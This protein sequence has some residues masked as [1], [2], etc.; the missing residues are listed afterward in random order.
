M[1]QKNLITDVAGVLVGNADDARLA[2]GVSAIIFAQPAVV[3]VDVRGG[4]PATR[5]TD[6]LEPHRTVERIDAVVLSGGSAF[7]L[8]AGAGAQAF[9]RERGR[10]FAIGDIRVPL[11]CGASLFDLLNGGDKNWG[12]LRPTAISATA[13]PRR[14][15]RVSRSVP[16]EPDSAPPPSI[17][18]AEW[19]L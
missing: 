12:R 2:S 10:G 11:V 6:L 3:A 18:R 16:R 17:S 8:D 5:D 19:A 13:P 4:A 14:P 15:A 1:A 7:G 9:L